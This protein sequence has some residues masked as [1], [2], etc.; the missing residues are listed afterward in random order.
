MLFGRGRD[1]AALAT[2]DKGARSS[3]TNVNPKY[4]D[5]V[6]PTTGVVQSRISGER[7]SHFVGNEEEGTHFEAGILRTKAVGVVLFLDIHD[8]LG[9]GDRFKRNVVVVAVL[10]DNE[11]P[12][13]F[14]QE[15]I[16][17]EIAIGHGGNG[18]NGVGIAA[19]HE[20]AE[21][22][23]NDVDFLAI[24]EFGGSF[25]NFFADDFADSTKLFVPVGIGAFAF[26]DHFAT[27]VYGAFGDQDDGVAAGIL[28]AVGSEQFGEMFDIEFVLRND[29]AIGGTG[30]GGKHGG[31]TRVPA[32]DLNHHETLVR[33][34]RGAETVD[35]LNGACDAGAEADAVVGAGNII[36]HGLGNA[37]DFEAF[38]VEANAVAKRVVSA[39]G[40]ES[41]DAQPSEI[42]ED[43][44]GEVVFLSGEFV[45]QMRGDAGLG[46][47]AGIGPGRV[48]ESATGA[49]G[50][51]DR[52]FV[53]EEKIVR[54][55]VILL[56]DHIHKAGPAMTNADNLVAFA[57]SAKGDAAD[58]G[59]QAGNVAA[60]GEDAD[61]A[62][63]SVDVCHEMTNCPFVGCSTLNYPLRRSF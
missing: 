28:A 18:V 10:E 50:A 36:V 33:A 40:D 4:V 44:R 39:D 19:A 9:G 55:V 1:D 51:I 61:D 6:S 21:L 3:S 41:V 31:E 11:T 14:F 58:G 63:L 30:H 35:H 29:A 59:I 62:F 17:S 46:D 49:V 60:S 23:I 43:F 7:L 20:I 5:R 56:A 2:D 47:A 27:F 15:E 8:F 12:A 42:F 24:V 37:D 32:E 26:E 34:G 52:L 16:E 53:K 48:E 13:D 45:F 57:N 22:L 38:F 25:S 54:V